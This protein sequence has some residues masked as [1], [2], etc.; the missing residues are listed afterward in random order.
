MNWYAI[1]LFFHV[2]A[3]VLWIGGVVF[4][5][6]FL[7]PSLRRGMPDIATRSQFLYR[8]LRNFFILVWILAGILL[9]TGYV[10]VDLRGDVQALM[11]GQ[12]GDALSAAQWYMVLLGHVMVAIALYVFFLPFLGMRRALGQ[13][14]W[15]RACVEAGRI[16]LFSMANIVIAVPAIGSGIWAIF[17]GPLF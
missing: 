9:I 8:M 13:E 4:L 10:M 5:D 14:N 12:W 15:D 1:A 17:G 7:V 6:F 3:V 11:R 2:N 16:R